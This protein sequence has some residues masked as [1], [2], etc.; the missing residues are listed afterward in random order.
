MS[1]MKTQT[2]R[3]PS[4]GPPVELLDLLEAVRSLP[5]SYRESLMPAV[6]EA[7]EQAKYRNNALALATDALKQLRL[8]LQVTQFDLDLTRIEREAARSA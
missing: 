4:G 8:D 1:T 6:A 3:F 2:L 7:I 5:E